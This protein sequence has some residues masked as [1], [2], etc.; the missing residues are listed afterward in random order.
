MKNC[1]AYKEKNV[2]PTERKPFSLYSILQCKMRVW[3]QRTMLIW[4]KNKSHKKL[5]IFLGQNLLSKGKVKW[6]ININGIFC[7]YF[8]IGTLASLKQ[9]L[10]NKFSSA[11]IKHSVLHYFSLDIYAIYLRFNILL[12]TLKSCL[13]GLLEGS[14]FTGSVELFPSFISDHLNF[15]SLNKGSVQVPIVLWLPCAAE[16]R[17][18]A[19]H[20]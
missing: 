12:S 11:E 18:I 6:G 3:S 10:L 17:V 15:L 4:H 8:N 20:D 14:K 7:R 1:I 5:N 9:S 16:H 2:V 19:L 13:L